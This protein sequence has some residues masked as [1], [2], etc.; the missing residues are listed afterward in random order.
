LYIVMRVVICNGINDVLIYLQETNNVTCL[1]AVVI[2]GT[3]TSI[4]LQ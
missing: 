4:G 1:P 3:C 2:S